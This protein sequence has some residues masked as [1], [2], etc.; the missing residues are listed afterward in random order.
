MQYR[1][2]LPSVY[3]Q[4]ANGLLAST[5]EPRHGAN[6][7]ALTQQVQDTGAIFAALQAA[8]PA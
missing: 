3:Q 8:L 6:G 2:G 5:S 1:S 7:I 4:P